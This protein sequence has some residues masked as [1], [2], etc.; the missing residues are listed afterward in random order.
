VDAFAGIAIP[1]TRSGDIKLIGELDSARYDGAESQYV[2]GARYSPQHSDF[3]IG[4]GIARHSV[5]VQV[6]YKFG[7]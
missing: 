6:G 2:L 7:K 5:F 4:A 3:N 1:V